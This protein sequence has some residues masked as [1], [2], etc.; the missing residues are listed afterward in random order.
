MQALFSEKDTAAFETLLA[1][2]MLTDPW[3]IHRTGSNRY[4]NHYDGEI[5][6]ETGM[7]NRGSNPACWER[8]M[9]LWKVSCR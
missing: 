4:A 6:G 3:E 9:M 7:F 5:E 2:S 8:E 1:F